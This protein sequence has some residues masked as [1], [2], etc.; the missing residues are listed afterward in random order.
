MNENTIEKFFCFFFASQNI[1]GGHMK[2]TYKLG[3]AIT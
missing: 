1:R 3:N 2:N